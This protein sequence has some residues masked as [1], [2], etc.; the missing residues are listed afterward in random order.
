MTSPAQAQMLSSLGAYEAGGAVHT[1][2]W[3]D[4]VDVIQEELIGVLMLQYASYTPSTI[5]MDFKV[6]AEAAIDD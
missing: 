6:L 4:P 2:F 5:G 3:F 1:N